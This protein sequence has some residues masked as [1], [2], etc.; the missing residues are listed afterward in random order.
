MHSKVSEVMTK[1]NLITAPDGT[2]LKGA[3][4]ILRQTKVEKLPVVD[5]TE[6]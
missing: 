4:R 2:D 1:E 6:S 5:G 3:E